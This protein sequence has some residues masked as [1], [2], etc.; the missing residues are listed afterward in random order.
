M[1][2]NTHG[3]VTKVNSAYYEIGICRKSGLKYKIINDRGLIPRNIEDRMTLEKNN[4][5]HAESLRVNLL[6]HRY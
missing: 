4:R 1:R 5:F 3:M 2:F 6:H